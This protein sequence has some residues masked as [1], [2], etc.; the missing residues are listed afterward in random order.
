MVRGKQKYNAQ[1]PGATGGYMDEEDEERMAL[2]IMH[3]KRVFRGN[4]HN[5]NLIKA[6]MTPQQKEELRIKA[7]REKKKVEMIK[8]QLIEFKKGKNKISP[9]DLRPG[10]PARIE[11]DLTYFLTEQ[12]KGKPDEEEVKVQTD[13]FVA[14]P[15]T[16]PYIPKKTG[17]DKITQ[18]WDTDLFNYDREVQPILNVLLTKTIEQAMLE[19]EEE[20]ELKEIRKFKAE[21]AKRRHKE[22]DDWEQ[23]VKKEVARIKQKNKTLNIARAKREQQIKTMHKLQCL[24]MSK[25]YLQKT[26]NSSL[27]YLAD[28]SYWRDTFQD[29]L[30]IIYKEWL[31]N[32]IEDNLTIEQKAAEFQD[33]VVQG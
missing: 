20:A 31:F 26:F 11:V 12:G 29:Q 7:E 25:H 32:K 9:Y 27:Q 18:I 10:P 33:S 4:T 13:Q 2:N 24:N 19:V 30:Q 23:E 28:C 6:N 17:I 15:P 21:Y 22:T 14:K 1:D 8:Q 5:V 16:P 3:D